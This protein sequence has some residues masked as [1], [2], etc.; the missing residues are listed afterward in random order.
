VIIGEIGQITLDNCIFRNNTADYYGGAVVCSGSMAQITHCQ[1][2]DNE[3]PSGGA[4][5]LEYSN[6][7]LEY[8]TFVGNTSNDGG[9]LLVQGYCNV[10]VSNCSFLFNG[11][12][13]GNGI[14]FINAS[15]AHLKVDRTLIAFGSTGEGFFWDG[16]DTLTVTNCDIYGNKD[17]DW[18]GEIADLVGVDNNFSL[19]PLHCGAPQSDFTLWNDSPCLPA[20]NPGGVLIGA[21]GLGCGVLAEAGDAVPGRAGRILVGGHPNPFNPRTT[22]TFRLDQAEQV[23]VGVYDLGG[24]LVAELV[25]QRFGAGLH[26]VDWQGRDVAGQ[27][28]ASGTYLVILR[29][30]G[31]IESQKISLLR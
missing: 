27:A 29:A 7:D 18:T 28:V 1:F 30:A 4:V 12:E 6:V 25:D 13:Q 24:Q 15:S 3:A 20:N 5:D 2:I 23:S 22:I 26:E 10:T 19:N 31:R 14:S 16:A 11:A 8:C 21:Y 9:G 17:G